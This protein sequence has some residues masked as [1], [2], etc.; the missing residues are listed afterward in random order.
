MER[1]SA[2]STILYQ[3]VMPLFF[4]TATVLGFLIFVFC[5]IQGTHGEPPEW[6]VK[7]IFLAAG[8]LATTWTI[9]QAYLIQSVQMDD[10]KIGVSGILGT[11]EIPFGKIQTIKETRFRNPKLVIIK[12]ASMSK[13]GKTVRFIPRGNGVFLGKHPML[14]ALSRKIDNSRGRHS[15][16]DSY[17]N[18]HRQ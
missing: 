8:A 18:Y 12:L 1:L 4:G 5:R 11:D 10:M 16:L 13:F 7:W 2:E 9:V 15:S 14:D 17:T 6:Y 3:R